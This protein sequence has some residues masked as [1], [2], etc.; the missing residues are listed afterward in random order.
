MAVSSEGVDPAGVSRVTIAVRRIIGSVLAV[1][2]VLLAVALLAPT[3]TDQSSMV[4]WLIT[5]LIHVGASSDAVSFSR[6]EFVMNVAIIAPATFLGSLVWPRWTWRDWTAAGFVAAALVELTQALLL[7][8]RDGSFS[9]I[10]AN[11][12]GALLGAVV[13]LAVTWLLRRFRGRGPAG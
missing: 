6:M 5:R 11:T 13:A 3:N 8:R 7:P 1:Y 10:V 12:L 2:L 4:H 9:D